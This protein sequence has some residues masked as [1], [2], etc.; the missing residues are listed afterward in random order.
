[1]SESRSILVTGATGF[2]G[3]HFTKH[4]VSKGWNTHIIIRPNSNTSPLSPMLSKLTIHH[5]KGTTESL[6]EI[7][8][9]AKPDIVIHLASMFLAHHS[10]H[11]ID[12]MIK[13]NILFGT[14]LVEAM[15]KN[16]IH[17]LINTGTSWQHFE[18]QPYN[19]VC[20]Y[21]ATKEAFEAILTYYLEVTP[22][23]VTTLK[24]FDTY[25]PHDFRPKLFPLLQK[26]AKE[27]KLLPMSNGEQLIDLVF[28]DDV[29]NA[30]LIAIERHF[31]GD[32]VK[33]E[34]FAVTSNNPI[35]LKEIVKI[36]EEIIG[37]HV[38]IEWGKRPYRNRE[39][40]IPWDK[41][42]ILPNWRPT[43]DLRAGIKKIELNQNN[44]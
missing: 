8:N 9:K 6:I 21:A 5:Y 39:V 20:L 33:K 35:S 37:M 16:N 30:Y 38:P 14:Q 17:H 7:I 15:V 11:D 18:N 34:E 43:Y 44:S 36:Y 25:G 26:T 13:S 3:S 32:C 1:M 27:Q 23:K 42:T 22:L 12:S 10:E 19:P 4:I 24:L 41:G 28:I 29:I 31:N 2:I 40:M